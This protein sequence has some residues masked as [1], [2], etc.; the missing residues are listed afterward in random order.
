[1]NSGFVQ[2]CKTCIL[3]FKRLFWYGPFLKVFIE[4]FT[5][6]LLFYV[7]V[8]TI[9]HVVLISLLL[10]L[11]F[12]SISCAQLF[13]TPQTVACKAPLSSTISQSLLKFMPVESVILSNH[14]IL[15]YPLLLLPLV[16]PSIRVFYYSSQTRY[17]THT[18]CTGKQS[19]SHWITRA[20][21]TF[22]F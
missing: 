16:F 5:T 15:W 9:W 18:P 7:L 6:L 13:V 14:L 17:Q 4:F 1:M 12:K 19:L 10:W 22:T 20:V 21:L 11:F 3:F 8:L 2:L